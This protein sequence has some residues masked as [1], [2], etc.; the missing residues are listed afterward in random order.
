M[1]HTYVAFIDES[2]D[3]G[4]DKPFRGIGD[5]GGPSNWLVIS[6]CLFRKTHSLDAVAWRDEI[7]AKMPERKSRQLH[8]A[9]LKHGQK[10]VA[11][12]TIAKK[13][14]RALSVIAAKNPIPEGIYKERNQLYFYMTRYLIERLS[15]LCRDHRRLAPEGDGRVA[16][17]FSRRGGMQYDEFRAYLGRLK[18]DDEGDVRIHWPV[19]DIDAVAAA[20]HSSSASL[21]LADAVASAFAAGFEPDRYGNCEPRYAET[22][23]PITYHRNKNY[24]SYGVKLVPNYEGCGLNQQQLKMI[25]VWK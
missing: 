23:K 12:Q 10:L 22:L 9:R 17:T 25:E 11:V 5:D 13:P 24:L 16:I 21:Q 1:S 4:L 7:S 15:W 14:L 8:F 20:D 18:D 2:G 19:I 6:A 3:D